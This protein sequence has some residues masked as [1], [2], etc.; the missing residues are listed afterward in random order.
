V[1][2]N[3]L[4]ERPALKERSVYLKQNIYTVVK[5]HRYIVHYIQHFKTLQ[6]QQNHIYI[7]IYKIE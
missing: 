1:L 6:Q 5:K 3:N 4:K 2:E 7:Y